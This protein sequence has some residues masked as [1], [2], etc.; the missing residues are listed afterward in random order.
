M[1]SFATGR[2]VTRGPC[3]RSD[4]VATWAV[5]V[6]EA[7]EHGSVVSV[8]P[9]AQREIAKQTE[10]VTE[11]ETRLAARMVHIRRVSPDS[12]EFTLQL[13]ER[14]RAAFA[15]EPAVMW[16]IWLTVGDVSREYTP[17]SSSGETASTGTVTLLI[18]LY[19]RG[20]MSA[21]LAKVTSGDLVAVS[22]PRV[23]LRVPALEQVL[24][25]SGLVFNLLAGGTGVAPCLQLLR[26]AKVAEASVRMLYSCWTHEDVL[27]AAELDELVACWPGQGFSYTLVLTREAAE[28]A[29]RQLK[30]PRAVVATVCGRHIDGTIVRE[31]LV[32]PGGSAEG[33]DGHPQAVRT[34]VSG[35]T[36]FNTCCEDLVRRTLAPAERGEIV[37]LDA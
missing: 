9:A 22:P 28:Q 11:Q 20:L 37:V 10:S 6:Y 1:V 21:Q 4:K 2:C 7:M 19:T 14:E 35:P 25:P 33:A 26:R 32:G 34:I 17:T 27:L 8:R 29:G 23:T 30:R 36:G 18:K 3:S 13:G 5:P 24:M 31:H 15:R 16:H 12:H